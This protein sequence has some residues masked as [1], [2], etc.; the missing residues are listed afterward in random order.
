MTRLTQD[1]ISQLRSAHVT[2]NLT[3][4]Q[5]ISETWT[6]LRV[7]IA[8]EA[9][10]N[11]ADLTSLPHNS[12]SPDELHVQQI[13]DPKTVITKLTFIWEPS[14][15]HFPIELLG[16]PRDGERIMNQEPFKGHLKIS[17]PTQP[18][19]TSEPDPFDD[20]EVRY[21]TYKETGWDTER[22]VWIYTWAD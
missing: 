5:L 7:H 17:H 2:I 13:P 12:I 16:G 18:V 6:Y 14:T 21:G 10:Q 19:V 20:P 4:E 22:K 1:E 3:D 9:A 11:I 15:E 8:E